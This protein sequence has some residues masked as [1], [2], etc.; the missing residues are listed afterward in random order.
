VNIRIFFLSLGMVA[1]GMNTMLIAGLLPDIAWT[2]GTTEAVVGVSVAVSAVTYAVTGPFI[3][4]VF[5]RLRRRVLMMSA[6]TLLLCGILLSAFAWD[7]TVFYLARAITGLGT[8][9][10][11]AQAMAT[12][13]QISPPGR[14]GSGAAWLG[15]GFAVSLALGVPVGTLLADA[16]G[17]RVAFLLTAVIAVATIFGL[18]TVRVAN[19]ADRP[20]LREQ[21]RPLASPALLVVLLA[22][23][24]YSTSYFVVLTYLHPI[25]V[26]GAG[27]DGRMVAGALAVFGACT[28][29]SMGVGGRLIDRFGGLPV[30]IVCV[31]VMGVAI[32]VMG[33]PIGLAAFAAIAAF[34][35]TGSLVGPASVVELGRMHPQNPAT[36][37]GANMSVVQLG[38]ALGS[39][40]GAALLAGLGAGWIAYA[41]GP[42][43]LIAAAICGGIV[44]VRRAR[45]TSEAVTAGVT[46]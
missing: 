23:L 5:S 10:Y 28:I 8:A 20:S 22:I 46:A 45:R 13:M 1:C 16:F 19:R 3:P 32:P 40:M 38:A 11:V 35:L 43:A 36:V 27:V 31:L 17:Y 44:L 26:D 14:E 12:A 9:A 6:M 18:T 7:I 21:L 34:G 25:L 2:L 30:V 29:V 39:A 4:V 15:M 42:P 24:L 37:V 33:A 41:A